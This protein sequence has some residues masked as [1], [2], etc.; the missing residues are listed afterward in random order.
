MS[1]FGPE[2]GS[3]KEIVIRINASTTRPATTILRRRAERLREG[4]G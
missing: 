1:V 4:N 2:V 3:R